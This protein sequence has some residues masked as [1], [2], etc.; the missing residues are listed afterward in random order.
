MSEKERIILLHKHNQ[1]LLPKQSRNKNSLALIPSSLCFQAF[2]DLSETNPLLKAYQD[3]LLKQNQNYLCFCFAQQL[4]NNLLCFFAPTSLVSCG[5]F[6]MLDLALPAQIPKE[7]ICVLFVYSSNALLCF[8]QNQELQYCKSIAYQQEE[9]ELCKR[10]LQTL[11]D[12]TPPLYCLSYI[13]PLPKVLHSLKLSALSSLFFTSP[14]DFG[15]HFQEIPLT[16][17]DKILPIASLPSPSF[18]LLRFMLISLCFF[19][20]FTFAFSFLLPFKPQTQDSNHHLAQ[21][22]NTLQSLKS[23]KT[24]LFALQALHQPLKNTPILSLSFSSEKLI[25][26]FKDPF[27]K[28]FLDLLANQ[29]YKSKVLNPTTLEIAL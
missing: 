12:Y 13:H 19:A 16:Q 15:L 4:K 5:K 2:Y 23:N 14:P 1:T 22:L 6:A 26:E 10:Y 9:I 7:K 18:R 3:R 24:L 29:G 25:V 17:Q 8:Y 28:D 27:D 11:F 21:V 20:L